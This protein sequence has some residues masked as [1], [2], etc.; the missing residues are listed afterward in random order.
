M[1][2]YF[3]YKGKII[4][5]LL[6]IIEKRF[7]LLIFSCLDRCQSKKVKDRS[8]LLRATGMFVE[9]GFALKFFI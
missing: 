1:S 6:F 4:G 7:F 2:I 3:K 8:T 9:K 5:L